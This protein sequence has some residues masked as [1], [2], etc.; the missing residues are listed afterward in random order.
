MFDSIIIG[1]WVITALFL[2]FKLYQSVQI[3]PNRE[4]LIV[5][6]LGRYHSNLQPG[7]HILIPFIERVAYRQT[8]KEQAIEVLPQI[9]ITKDNVQVKV[10]GILY[11]VVIDAKNASYGIDDYTFAAVQ[12]AQTSMRAIIGTMDLDKTFE[13]RGSINQKIVD[14][15]DQSSEIWG[16]RVTRYEIQNLTPPKSVIESMEKQKNAELKKKADI[17]LSEGDRNSRVNRSEGLKQEA[18][19]KSEGEKQKRI[20]E[21]EG[22]ASEILSIASASAKGISMIAEAISVGSGKEAL[23]LQ[24]AEKYINQIRSL[25]KKNTEVVLPMDLSDLQAVRKS[26]EDFLSNK[27]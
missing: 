20:N 6:R 23:K 12:L 4:V 1:F 17:S 11:I 18:I 13:A 7:F 27:K 5:E 16:I 3:V 26:V 24:I 25:A 10:D 9:C 19:N 2:C 22:Q 8:L 14:I 15:I 21:A